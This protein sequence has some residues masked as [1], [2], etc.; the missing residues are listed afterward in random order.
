[1]CPGVV[2]MP[3]GSVISPAMVTQI[4]DVCTAASLPYWPLTMKLES[5]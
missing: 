2:T 4:H 5:P 1:M 3:T